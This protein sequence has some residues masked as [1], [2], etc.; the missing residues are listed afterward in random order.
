MKRTGAAL[1]AASLGVIAVLGTS[2]GT[3]HAAGGSNGPVAFG[4]TAG[5]WLVAF[6][7]GD[8]GEVRRIGEIS[9]LEGDT[10]LVGIDFRVQ[11]GK[12]YGVG[13]RGGVYVVGRAAA[14]AREVSRLTVP[15]T[16]TRF[17]VDFNPAADRLRI[18]S[19]TGQ[20]LRHDV[21][22]GGTTTVDTPLTYPPAVTPAEG[23]VAVGYTNND[24]DTSTSTTL[25]DLDVALD[26]LA[27]QAPANNGTLSA[28]G[29]LG[30][31]AT[32]AGLDVYSAVTDGRTVRNQVYATLRVEG[33]WRF[34]RVAPLTG[35]V[36]VVGRYERG[37]RVTDVAVKLDQG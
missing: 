14:G 26:Q 10:R 33:T 31:G 16:G 1:A 25:F 12:L 37:T 23:I 2:A 3:G 9:G 22:P 7:V 28:T 15:L 30:V 4:L 29:L 18:V 36:E 27:I 8:P 11:D 35:D 34:Y 24:L 13:D 20:N 19:D 32:N 21:N 6:P 5:Q 17:G